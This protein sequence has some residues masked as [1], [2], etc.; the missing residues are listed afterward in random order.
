M[1]FEKQNLIK[2]PLNYVGGK[3]KLLPKILPL[4]PDKINTFVDL[5]AGGCNVGVNVVAKTVI[6]NDIEKHVIQLLNYFKNND[7]SE[8]VD[9]IY[10]FIHKYEL[11][12]TATYGYE[13][14]G[15]N[16]NNGVAKYNKIKYEKMRDD[17]NTIYRNDIIMFYTV[18]IFAFNNQI[19]FNSKGEYKES[20]NKR[21]FNKNLK[22]NLIRFVDK[23]KETN[24]SFTNFD[25]KNIDLALFS[26][27]D[28]FYCDPPYLITSAHYNKLWCEEDETT[29]LKFL[30]K[31]NEKGV[32]LL[33]L[34]Y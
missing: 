8:I 28:L 17:F 32:D 2:S 11:S 19:K 29:L 9:S 13:Y 15:C 22:K 21:D 25:Y 10:K 33:Y 5:F 6:C 4:F 24:I 18:M 3:Y 20:V 26:S 31:L 7:S 30:D 34:M 23:L 12:D 1:N 27:D 14:Y 16:S